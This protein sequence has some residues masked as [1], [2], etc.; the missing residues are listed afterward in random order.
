M[1]TIVT[2]IPV[3]SVNA[4]AS[5]TNGAPKMPSPSVRTLMA[6]PPELAAGVDEHPATTS[7]P[8]TASPAPTTADDCRNRLREIER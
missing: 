6:P 5:F 4:W 8:A 3:S 7:G 1:V 2:G